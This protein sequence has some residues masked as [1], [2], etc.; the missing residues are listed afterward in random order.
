MRLTGSSSSDVACLTYI[1]CQTG[2]AAKHEGRRPFVSFRTAILLKT[3]VTPARSIRKRFKVQFPIDGVKFRSWIRLLEYLVHASFDHSDEL[4]EK[5]FKQ[6]CQHLTSQLQS[7]VTDIITVID[8]FR[9]MHTHEYSPSH[10]SNVQSLGSEVHVFDFNVWYD[11]GGELVQSLLLWSLG[12][13]AKGWETVGGKF[14]LVRSIVTSRQQKDF[15]IGLHAHGPQCDGD[16]HILVQGVVLEV[17]QALLGEHVR[18]RLD[19]CRVAGD[20]GLNDALGRFNNDTVLAQ[21]LLHKDDLL[22]TADNE[23]S[24]RINSAFVHLL[25]V[26][27]VDVNRC[28][29]RHIS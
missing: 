12:G 25:R 22:L 16:R 10:E 26:D 14:I 20:G 18:F 29:I 4:L 27:D 11:G 24:T 2:K 6:E 21:L 23:I 3:C 28:S 5:I 7:L 15:V 13:F 8:Q 9:I 19:I 17:Y 1:T